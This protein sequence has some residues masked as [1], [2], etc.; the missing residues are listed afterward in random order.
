VQEQEGASWSSERRGR[1]ELVECKK[2]RSGYEGECVC[3]RERK[4]ETYQQMAVLGAAVTTLAFIPLKKPFAP[5]LLIIMA[6]PSNKPF[7]FLI[8]AS[9]EL[10]LV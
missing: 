10:P 5:S 7:A 6:A 2:R 8:S 1:S 9:V 4:R 3:E